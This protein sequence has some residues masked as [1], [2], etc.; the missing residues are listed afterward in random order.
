MTTLTFDTLA[1]VK[2]LKEAGVEEKQAEAQAIALISVLKHSTVELAT[3][4]D[5][6]RL[7]SAMKTDVARLE[8][9]TK[10]DIAQLAA[11]TKADIAQLAAATKE[12]IVH[13]ESRIDMMGER[14]KGQFTLLQWMAGFNLALSVALLWL[15]V[16]SMI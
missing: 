3:R 5:I 10:T 7:E 11:T 8:T 6:E 16:R 15:F 1:Y 14:T 9:S 2:T 4:A 13:L 12:D